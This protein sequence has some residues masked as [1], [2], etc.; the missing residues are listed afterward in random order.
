MTTTADDLR[1][2]GLA[3]GAIG[4]ALLEAERARLG[5]V[6]HAK[7][8]RALATAAAGPLHVGDDASLLVGA[9]AVAFVLHHAA[10]GT[11]RY[12]A[13]LHH[14]D[15]QIA[16]IAQRRLD[17]SHA[18]IDRHEPARTSEFDLFYGL[19]GIGAYLLARDH[20]TLRDVLVYLVRLTE[21]NDGLP[22]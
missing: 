21:E 8:H 19:T 15:A 22:G 12:G 5:L 17:A 9:P 6:P 10:A 1:A 11:A 3:N 14:L 4:R 13:A 20:H 16:A 7:E 2:Q 18:R